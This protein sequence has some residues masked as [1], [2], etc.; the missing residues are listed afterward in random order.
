VIP[1]LTKV[2]TKL[3]DDRRFRESI[4]RARASAA[5]HE[6]R[7]DEVERYCFF[8]GFPRSGSTLVGQLLNAHRH[9]A[10]SHE[11]D[12]LRFV[13]SG[14]ARRS[15]LFSV[16]LER[17]RAFVDRGARGA[18]GYAFA[19][20]GQWQGKAEQLRVI[21]DKRAASSASRLGRRPDLLDQL[22]EVVAVPIRVINVVRNP[23]D[24]ISTIAKRSG[25][26]LGPVADDYF[27]LVDDVVATNARAQDGELHQVRSEAL[28]ADPGVELTRLCAFLGVDSPAD[29]LEACSS[30]VFPEARR[31][32]MSAP[33]T[34]ELI[35]DVERRVAAVELLAGYTYDS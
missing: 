4:R 26:A 24:N 23:F 14:R 13:E 8:V 35:A 17:D 20:P 7:I 3:R 32:R 15:E 30:I 1:S 16:I 34:P 11:S 25:R 6:A 33:W 21:G 27:K 22:R 19:V 2:K 9:I 5:G 28:V 10:I 18:G 29:Y 12:A 31:T